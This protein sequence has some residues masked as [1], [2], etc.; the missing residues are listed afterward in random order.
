[1]ASPKNQHSKSNTLNPKR[2]LIIRVKKDL[3]LR[4]LDL[5]FIRV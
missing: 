5:G 3:V 4:I 1:M 2:E